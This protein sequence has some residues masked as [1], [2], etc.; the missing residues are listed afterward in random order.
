MKKVININFQG[1]VIAIEE[2]A[3]ELLNQYIQ[4]LKK[5]FSREEGGDEIVNDIENRIA[6]LFGN[7]LKLGINCITDEDVQSIVESIGKPEDFDMEYVESATDY[8]DQRQYNSSSK[9]D[10]PAEVKEPKV[11]QRNSNDRIIAG[12][13]SGLAHYFKTDPVWVRLIFVVFFS[14]LFW[15]YL[16]LWIVLKTAPLESNIT[17]RLYRNPNNKVLGGVCSGIAAYFKI[18][19]WIPRVLFLLPLFLSLVGRVSIPLFPWNKMFNHFDFNWNLNFSILIVYVVLWIIIPKASTIKQKLKMMGE[20]DY[21]KSIRETVSDNVASVRSK[22]EAEQAVVVAAD[23]EIASTDVSDN[24]TDTVTMPPVPPV[25][26]VQR[27]VN[28]PEQPAQRSGCLSAIIIFLKIIL[29]A[30]VGLFGIV[31]VG[32]LIAFLFTGASFIPL[33]SLFIDSGVET[34]MLLISAILLVIVPVVSI[35]LWIVRR[36]MKL[37]SRPIIGIISLFLWFAGIITAGV[38]TSKVVEK[39][40]VE[41][42]SENKIELTSFTGDKLYLEM[43]PYPEDYYTYNAGVGPG[44]EID[45]LPYYTI[46]EDSLLFSDIDLKIVESP[47][48]LFHL[49]TIASTYGA[50]LKVAKADIREFNYDITQKDSILYLP[51]FFRAPIKQGFR[52]QKMKVEV[53]V[54]AGK[55]VEVAPELE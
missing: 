6:E 14:I 4:S 48:S 43:N 44:S 26:P 20:E 7:R 21:I 22:N 52:N 47:D 18:D 8:S 15:A 54:P 50:N 27:V 53:S 40:K 42:T 12:V 30:F 5:Y 3:Y 55:R 10:E 23:S 49:R 9:V 35:T 25:P 33:K 34:N 38:L 24:S 2:T 39:F 32:I 29:F 17:K 51:E 31:L 16:I 45:D 37:K 41:S 19:T 36:S 1:Q 13:C 11:L 28:R 46:N